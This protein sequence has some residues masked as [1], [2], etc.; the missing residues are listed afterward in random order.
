[1]VPRLTACSLFVLLG[2]G[3]SCG[4]QTPPE[5]GTQEPGRAATVQVV[6]HNFRDVV[7]YLYVGRIR[8]RLGL[9]GG[10][11]VTVFKVP[12]NRSAGAHQVALLGEQL[13]DDAEVVSDVFDLTP[14]NL[15]VWTIQPS[16]PGPGL[17]GLWSSS[18]SV[19]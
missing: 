15:V 4:S 13:A 11:Q 6:S 3:V 19:Y 9:A 12:W 17:P 7:V 1:M 8:Q 2:I 18:L 5:S 14:G 10:N 16:P